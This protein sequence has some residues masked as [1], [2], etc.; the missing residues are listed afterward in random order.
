MVDDQPSITILKTEIPASFMTMDISQLRY[1]DKNP[2]VYSCIY[3]V[4]RPEDADELQGLIHDKMKQEPSVTNLLPQIKRHGGLIEPI[5]VR[6]DTQEVIEGNSRLAAYR[7]LFDEDAANWGRI[8]CLA[9]TSLTAE[10]QDAY[11]DEMHVKGKTQ[12][13]AYEK[14]NF[15]YV[16]FK[17]GVAID[18]ISRR[19]DESENEINKRIRTIELMELNGDTELSRYSYYDVLIRNKAIS[20][21]IQTDLNLKN[22]ILTEIKRDEFEARELRDKLPVVL[23]KPKELKKFRSGRLSLDDAYQNA[24]VSGPKNLISGARD[25]VE[26]VSKTDINKLEKSDLKDLKYELNKLTREISRVDRIVREVEA[27]VTNG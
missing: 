27:E 2:R 10:Q 24:R 16:R 5:L 8:K 7:I 19:F 22:F 11:L 26:S 3:G 6:M 23:K 4:D 17:E 9:V 12:W 13:T 18:E 14:A 1:Y 25:R 20:A 21:A 15:A